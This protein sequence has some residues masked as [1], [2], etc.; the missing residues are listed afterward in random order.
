MYD[1]VANVVGSSVGITLAL[2]ADYSWTSWHEWRR[3]RGGKQEAEYQR[4]LM[5]ETELS[6]DD[7]MDYHGHNRHFESM[8]MV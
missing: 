5:D 1:I 6:D 7:E 4:A 3:R 8:E 2:I